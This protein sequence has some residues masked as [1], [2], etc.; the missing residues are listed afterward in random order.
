MRVVHDNDLYQKISGQVTRLHNRRV[1]IYRIEL[2]LAEK[3]QL[4][5]DGLLGDDNMLFFPEIGLTVPVKVV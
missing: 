3:T 2:T 5:L 4:E 1:K